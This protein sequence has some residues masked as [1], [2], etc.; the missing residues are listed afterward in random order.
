[1]VA[2]CSAV[3]LRRPVHDLGDGVIIIGA[4]MSGLCMAIKLKAAGVPCVILEQ[5]SQ[6]GGTWAVNRYPGCACDIPSHLYGYS[7]APNPG[8]SQVWAGRA[9]LH[10]YLEGVVDRF[11]IRPLLVLGVGA[12]GADFDRASAT[13]TVRGDDGQRWRA[14][15]VV[16]A[17][18][19]LRV[20]RYPDIPGRG[21]FA[22]VS[23]HTARWQDVDLS[24]KRVAIIGTGA[25]AV[26]VIPR[27]VDEVGHL[28]VYQRTP[29]YVRPKANRR[30]TRLEQWAMARIPGAWRLLR[31]SQY[32]RHA[33][34][35][36]LVFTPARPSA[37]LLERL[38]RHHI[39]REIADPELRDKLMPPYRLGCKR[40]L[41]ESGYYPAL[42]RDNVEVVTDSIERIDESGLWA[43]GQHRPAEVLV[44]ATGFD[45][46][47]TGW[48]DAVRAGGASMGEVYAAAPRAYLGMTAP[49]YPNF[50]LLLGPSTGLGHN[51][52]VWMMERQVN[53]IVALLGQ[54]KRNGVRSIEAKQ[55]MLDAFDAQIQRRIA[56][57]V[58]VQG[59]CASWY[60][61]S[62]GK[63]RALWPDSTVAYW[64]ALRRVRLEDYTVG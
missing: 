3:S 32:G 57:R 22:G 24:G 23:M 62:D 1:M 9:E 41:A 18:G 50:F 49:G 42:Q 39:A 64:R 48:L 45:I 5:S 8:W 27:I 29:A 17:I 35:F 4:G 12:T 47:A 54:M 10:A 16:S 43:G 61:H 34:N 25:S 6:L 53:Y 7:F 44:H 21:D 37:W 46:W 55:S 40:V 26:Q 14:R 51:S 59:G 38:L 36:H 15:A 63:V 52:V 13:W 28:T 19:P 20:P 56:P 58:W 33:L 2:Y 60:Q 31:W 30:Y 11:G